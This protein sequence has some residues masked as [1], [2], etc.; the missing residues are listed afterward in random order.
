MD[1]DDLTGVLD[2]LR[3]AEALKST[4]RTSKTVSGRAESTA[5]HTWRL[6]LMVMAFAD[7]LDGIDTLKLIKMCLIHDL[8]EAVSGDVPATARP[9]DGPDKADRE[10]RDLS[11]LPPAIPRMVGFT[12]LRFSPWDWT[13]S[14]G[15]AVQTCLV[16]IRVAAHACGSGA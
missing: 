6:C 15:E 7:G 5:E 13:A 16:P 9:L 11:R 2:F 10:R 8:G 3:R 12:L 14:V 4:P 1:H